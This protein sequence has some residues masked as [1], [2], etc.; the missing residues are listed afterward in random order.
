MKRED[1]RLWFLILLV[2]G[3]LVSLTNL[4]APIHEFGHWI[5]AQHAGQRSVWKGWALTSQAASLKQA[6]AGYW[7]EVVIFVVAG[8]I[9]AAFGGK[10]RWWLCGF[11][12]GHAAMAMLLAFGSYDFNTYVYLYAQHVR[13]SSEELKAAVRSRWILLSTVVILINWPIVYFCYWK[14]LPT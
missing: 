10:K 3:A 8:H 9:V 2:V 11:L 5:T 13:S 4:F 7:I 14:R 6:L 12:F 1:Q